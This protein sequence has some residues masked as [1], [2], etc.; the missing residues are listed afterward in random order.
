[1]SIKRPQIRTTY[2]FATLEISKAAY[3]EIHAKLKEAGYEH[4]FHEDGVIHMHGI[5][6]APEPKK[7]QKWTTSLEAKGHILTG[8]ELRFAAENEVPVFYEE[9]YHDP[10]IRGF[11][12]VSVME[13]APVGYYIG[14]SDIN[15]NEFDDNEVVMGDFPEGKYVVYG[16]KGHKYS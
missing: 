2:T 16:V 10:A 13:K 7:K 4:T 5:G 14:D 15:P 9:D 3:D 6:L 8:K 1:M 12:G 11:F